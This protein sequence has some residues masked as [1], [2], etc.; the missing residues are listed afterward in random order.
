MNGHTWLVTIVFGIICGILILTGMILSYV[1]KTNE[2]IDQV[3][4]YGGMG[5][6]L[7]GLALIIHSY[8]KD[9]KE[10]K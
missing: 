6:I 2:T 4:V 5:G 9:R 10:E 3:V 1:F 7:S 8:I